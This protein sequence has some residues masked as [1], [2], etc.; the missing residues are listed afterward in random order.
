V[1][2]DVSQRIEPGHSITDHVHLYAM[3]SYLMIRAT[4]FPDDDDLDL[5]VQLLGPLLQLLLARRR[6]KAVSVDGSRV[7]LVGV[8]RDASATG[9]VVLFV[10]K[11]VCRSVRVGRLLGYLVGDVTAGGLLSWVDRHVDVVWRV[12]YVESLDT[13]FESG[14]VWWLFYEENCAGSGF[15]V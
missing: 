9:C 6:R 7:C 4:S 12:C 15:V 5:F 11:R 14:D 10:M 1:H 3:L 8:S 2:H 13:L